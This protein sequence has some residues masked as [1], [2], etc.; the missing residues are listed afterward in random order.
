MVDGA[1]DRECSKTES[2][3]AMTLAATARADAAMLA[4]GDGGPCKLQQTNSD[5]E[6]PASEIKA[7]CMC[8]RQ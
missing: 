2:K 5:N 6:R 4:L 3:H 8:L 1:S 7:P